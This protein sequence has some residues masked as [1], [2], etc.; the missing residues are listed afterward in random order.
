MALT[1][2]RNTVA[3]SG[4]NYNHPVAANVKIYAGSLVCLDADTNQV[5]I[6]FI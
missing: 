6:E 5:W 1:E 3:R 2:D 4:S